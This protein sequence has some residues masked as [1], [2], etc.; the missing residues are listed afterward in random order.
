MVAGQEA[1]YRARSDGPRMMWLKALVYCL[2]PGM[3]SSSVQCGSLPQGIP[4]DR[5]PLSSLV[6]C[7]GVVPSA[8]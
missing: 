1:Y 2:V 6:R 8:G 5:W 3:S 4:L 7:G